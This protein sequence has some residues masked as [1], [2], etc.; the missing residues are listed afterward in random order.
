[1]TSRRLII[2]LLLFLGLAA[3]A[4]FFEVEG[5]KW[6]EAKREEQ[7]KLV[8]IDV[9]RVTRLTLLPSNIEIRKVDSHYQ[10]HSPVVT[11]A[12]SLT[13]ATIL[14]NLRWMKKG[15]FVSDNPH[16][17][18]KF[19][20]VPYQQAMVIQ[21]GDRID[22]LFIGNNNLD[23]SECYCRKNGSNQV[24]LVPISLKNSATKSLFDVRDKSI[25]KFEPKNIASVMITNQGKNFQCQ[26]DRQWRW[27][28]REPI[29]AFADE[30]RL[31]AMLNQLVDD[32][33]KEIASETSDELASYALD[34]P[35]LTITLYDSSNHP[36]GR[37][38]VGRRQNGQYYA[39]DPN[40]PAVLLIDSSLVARLNVSL[41]DL[42]DKTIANF[43]PDSVTTILLQRPGL[44]FH[45]RKDSLGRWVML[46]PDSALARSWKINSLLYKIKDLKV[47][48]FIDPPYRS[49]QHYGFDRPEIQLKLMKGERILA[50]FIMGKAVDDKICL[51]NQLT[52]AVHLV[53]Q[54][55]KQELSV[56]AAD[57]TD[58]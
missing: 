56:V 10:I 5:G 29:S 39:R 31:D 16:D 17:L 11:D 8:Q 55:A 6:R 12:D 40:R 42:R 37:L 27:W 38:E 15:R 41:Y 45:C 35:W 54:Q 52:K 25:L 3:Y 30:D 33:V 19:G 32:K 58:K 36:K 18:A 34:R 4:Y 50:D 49:D 43:E 46:Q 28:I 48:Q 22:S 9:A 20:L 7:Q 44:I 51:K 1:M 14:D 23:G 47:A 21:Q 24:F 57:F 26:R 53:K 2:L 13:I